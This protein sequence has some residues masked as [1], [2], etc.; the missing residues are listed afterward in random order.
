M[1]PLNALVLGVGGNVS[2]SIQ[3]ALRLATVPT[4]VVAACITPTAPGLYLADRAYISPPAAEPD[5]IPWL[6]EICEREQIDAVLSGSELVLEAVAAHARALRERTGAVAIVSSVE[7]L[8]TGRDKLRSC[9]WLERC[10]LPVPGYADF[11]DADAVQALIARCGFPL[12]AKPRFGKGSDGILIIRDEREL[13]RVLSAEDLVLRGVVREG[14]TAG[15]LILQEYL[16]DPDEEYTAGCFCDSDGELRGTIVLRRT[17][18]GGTTVTAELGSFPEVRD[19]AAAIASSLGALGP[20]NVQ[21]R[22]HHGRAVPFEINPRFS[23][24]T[25]LRARMGFNEVD[26]ALRHFVRG[27]PVPMLNAVGDGV[28]LRY[29]SEVYVPASAVAEIGRVGRLD[30]PAAQQ[31]RVEDWGL[32]E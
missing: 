6:T 30:D 22:V 14:L 32:P 5:F 10:G 15:D 3:K 19:T 8:A 24:T 25:A 2:Q 21:L 12:V 26:A 29:W 16:G 7:V 18:R 17:L 20:C 28:A 27:E 1:R 23:G 31:S 9:R 4:R 13:G 11:A